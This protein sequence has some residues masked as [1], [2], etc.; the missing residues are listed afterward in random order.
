MDFNHRPLTYAPLTLLRFATRI[1]LKTLFTMVGFEPTI[2]RRHHPLPPYRFGYIVNWCF[3]FNLVLNFYSALFYKV[4]NQLNLKALGP[5]RTDVSFTDPDYKSGA[6]DLYAT[7]ARGRYSLH[8]FYDLPYRLSHRMCE[9]IRLCRRWPTITFWIPWSRWYAHPCTDEIA[10]C[11][12]LPGN[13]S[14]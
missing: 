10:P 13:D 3:K 12:I 5:I 11:S 2:C 14:F 8:E 4:Y 6:I 1:Q 7:K 9:L